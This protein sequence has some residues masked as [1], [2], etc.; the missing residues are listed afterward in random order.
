MF[1]EPYELQVSMM[2]C[3]MRD[4]SAG[5]FVKDCVERVD[6]PLVN[7]NSDGQKRTFASEESNVQGCLFPIV[8]N[9]LGHGASFIILIRVFRIKGIGGGD[10]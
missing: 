8:Q 9:F 3:V 6:Q 4:R 2:A 10:K 1:E 7:K 5:A